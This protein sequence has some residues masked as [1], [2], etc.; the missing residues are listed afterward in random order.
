MKNTV[1]IFA[2]S[3][4]VLIFAC[5]EPSPLIDQGRD[6]LEAY[7]EIQSDTLYAVSDTFI[8]SG[9]I[10]TGKSPKILLGSYAD[11]ET[12]FLIKFPA[13]PPD[14]M[15]MDSLRLIIS[16]SSDFGDAN[17]PL[18]GIAY[19]VTE[20]WDESVNKDP[21]WNYR[22][23]IDYSPETT[24]TFSLPGQDTTVYTD[25]TINL[26]AKIAEIWQ[27]TVGGDQNHGVLLDF[28]NNGCIREFSSR[29]G[30]FSTRVPRIVYVYHT[31]GSD[32]TISDTIIASRDASLID[33]T[34]ILDQSN[35]Y[36]ISGYATHAFLEFDFS[37]IPKN[38]NI[39]SVS[40]TYERDSVNSQINENRL[41][42][43]YMRNVTTDFNQLPYYEIDSTFVFSSRHNIVLYDMF[44]SQ[45]SLDDKFR[46]KAGQ[47]FI[48][49]FINEFV[50]HGSFFI[51]YTDEG[52][53]VSVYALKRVTNPYRASRPRLILE[54]FV[55][56]GGRL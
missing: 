13:V 37:A 8:V 52:D 47:F 27:D 17:G 55:N 34:G 19:R 50:T 28:Q 45:L 36:V 11:F 56:P 1:Y 44:D 32:S 2:L 29:E 14:T 18:E 24:T 9:K 41:Q 3:I 49:D 7:G 10:N 33:F 12:R 31:P 53:D 38:A 26:S 6:L 23:K 42:H 20:T 15:I 5:T 25:F 21:D 22:E 35:L 48:Q 16:S 54:Y 4:I 51:Q 39:S 30:Y 40:F 46:A 43:L